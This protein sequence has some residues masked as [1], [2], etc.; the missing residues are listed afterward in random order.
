MQG[1]VKQEIMQENGESFLKVYWSQNLLSKKIDTYN[2]ALGELKYIKNKFFQFDAIIG[3]RFGLLYTRNFFL[4][5][6]MR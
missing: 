1:K 3:R 6:M 5:N 4:S 2:K